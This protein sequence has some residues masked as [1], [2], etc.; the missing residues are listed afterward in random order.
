MSPIRVISKKMGELLIERG[1]ISQENLQVALRVQKE[2][3]GYISQHLIGLGYV[4]EFDVANC[5]ASQYGFA[6]LPLE[7]YSIP[8]KVL[9]ILPLKI[10]RIY[11]LMPIDKIG[12]AL[13][14]TMADPLNDGVIEMLKHITNCEIKVFISTYSELYKAIDKYYGKNMNESEEA[15]MER[16]DLLRENIVHS[17]IQTKSYAGV[18]RR[19][20][21]RID[22]D[23]LSLLYFL[24]GKE[25]KA[26]V[27]NISYYGV[28]FTCDSFLPIDTNLYTNIVCKIQMQDEVL[29]SV[30]QVVR[31]ERKKGDD[32]PDNV[33][34]SWHYGI[35]GFYNFMT[36][37][38]R[39]KLA[40]F[41]SELLKKRDAGSKD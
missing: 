24:E 15:S 20:D 36:K 41:L 34:P 29:H 21:I 18:E 37:D 7:N 6:Y 14:V 10:I 23:G 13:T 2:K 1:I 27:R 5:L 11:C 4:T 12:N 3:G 28:Y 8:D 17:F 39:H 38:D 26:V 31:V 9:N 25:Y 30:V 32:N 16:K 40:V 22:V 33:S 35:A 19:R